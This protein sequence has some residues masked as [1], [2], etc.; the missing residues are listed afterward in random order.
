MSDTKELAAT[1]RINS[2]GIVEKKRAGRFRPVA[3]LED[4]LADPASYKSGVPALSGADIAL[5][6]MEVRRQTAVSKRKQ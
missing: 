6:Q 5:L 2:E 4:V 3:Y 1:L